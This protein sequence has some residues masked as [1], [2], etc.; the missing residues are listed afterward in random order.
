LARLLAPNSAA[1]I[2]TDTAVRFQ[3][4][5]FIN[6][7]LSKAAEEN[8]TAAVFA[9]RI[10]LEKGQQRPKIAVL[11]EPFDSAHKPYRIALSFICVS[12]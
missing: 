4:F 6:N 5:P 2:A 1:A 12:A 9:R 8:R 11:V 10:P 3:Y 7:F